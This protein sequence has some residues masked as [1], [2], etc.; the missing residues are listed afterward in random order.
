MRVFVDTNIIAYAYDKD[1]RDRHERAAELVK[2]LWTSTAPPYISTQVLQ[3]LHATLDKFGYELESTAKAVR[4]YMSWNV[5]AVTPPLIDSAL[6][7][8][9]RWK[10]SVWDSTIVAA[11]LVAETEQLWTED[12]QH[13]QEIE[14]LKIINPLLT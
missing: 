6:N 9:K 3:E 10:L 11:A 7:L 4:H 2:E 8:R 13:E 14:G 5:V 1:A 12:M